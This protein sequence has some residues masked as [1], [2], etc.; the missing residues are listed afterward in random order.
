MKKQK[1]WLGMPVNWDY[2]NW[3]KGIWD[4]ND[5]TLFPPKRFGIGWT[6]NFHELL[7]RARIIKK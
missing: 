3:H 7:K 2:K 5:P 6:I 1:T 4:P